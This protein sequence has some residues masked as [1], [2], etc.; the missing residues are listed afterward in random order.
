MIL[1]VSISF[2]GIYFQNEAI[3]N[4][5]FDAIYEVEKDFDNLVKTDTKMLMSTLDVLLQ[6]E[7]FMSYYLR[8]DRN[9]LYEYGQLL[10]SDL[11]EQYDITHF[12]F[13]RED[14][15][16][17]VRMHNKDKYDDLVTRFTFKDAERTNDVGVGLE[18]GKTAF[19]LRV[20]KPYYKNGDLI[21]YIELGQEI[22][23]F[24]D[25]LKDDSSNEFVIVSEKQYLDENS[26]ESVREV[27][28]LRNNWNDF[29]D[30]VVISATS[31]DELFSECFN[32]E[33]V[34]RVKDGENVLG[35]VDIGERKFLCGGFS[36]TDAGGRDSAAILSVVDVTDKFVYL[37][38][39][40]TMMVVLFF[41]FII[42]VG[43]FVFGVMGKFIKSIGDLTDVTHDLQKGKFDVNVDIKTGDELEE[44][45]NAFNQ[46]AKVLGTMD[47]EK[48]QLESAKTRFL[49]ITS[50]E[51]RS[52]MTPMKAQLE[53]LLGGYFGKLN[54]KQRESM[55]I[56]LRNTSRLDRIIVDFLEI[57]RIEAARLKFEFEK[58]SLA[59]HIKRLKEEMKGFM[60]DKNIEIVLRLGNLPVMEVDPNRV[61]QVL[62]NLI[63][64]A[65]KFSHPN[66]K[67]IVSG[68]MSKGKIIISVKDQGIGM[69]QED[70]IKVFEPFYQAEQSI[71]REHQGTGLGLAICRGIVE[72]QDGKIWIESEKGKGTTF[73]FNIPLTPVREIRAIKLL[74]SSQTAN[75][76]KVKELLNDMLGPMA[77]KEFDGLKM[78][79]ELTNEKLYNYINSLKTKGI[80][81]KEVAMKFKREVDKIFGKGGRK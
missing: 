63:N 77:D 64:N 8:G 33:N 31:D 75:E 50:H 2:V 5:G 59:P 18:L 37:F 26:W 35:F 71:Y 25:V 11:K 41:I 32:S 38:N 72:S 7:N 58:T 19:A 46:T 23:K 55:D 65:I 52:P 21:G 70:T 62:R 43:F 78:R 53:M 80:V 79:S 66:S 36:I 76:K 20:V 67:I 40:Q 39:T 42:V 24:L 29:E 69:S 34:E 10:F 27:A 28:E 73:Y 68:G 1:V 49:S 15:T 17:F 48:K 14:G 74:F 16:C 60:P 4:S 9:A 56:V 51:L 54:K 3:S 81:T 61:Y 45:G 22:D 12:Y 47:V 6:D 57:S 30:Y 13:I 44:L